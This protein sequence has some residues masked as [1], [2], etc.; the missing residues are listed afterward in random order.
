MKVWDAIR[1]TCSGQLGSR[2]T[3][4]AH[5]GAEVVTRLCLQKHVV[6]NRLQFVGPAERCVAEAAV[7]V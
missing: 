5:A 4:L 2:V 1:I 3:L 6:A 7:L